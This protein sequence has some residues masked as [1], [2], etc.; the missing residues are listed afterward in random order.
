MIPCATPVGFTTHVIV[1][2]SQLV[3]WTLTKLAGLDSRRSGQSFDPTGAGRSQIRCEAAWLTVI[4]FHRKYLLMHKNI[5]ERQRRLPASAY[6]PVITHTGWS[7]T[8]REAEYSLPE[9]A[10]GKTTFGLWLLLRVRLRTSL[11]RQ[12]RFADIEWWELPCVSIDSHS[13]S[14]DT[15]LSDR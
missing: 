9:F 13:A 4:A 2:P 15:S 3:D 5:C 12:C 14:A 7:N 6:A 10:F 11:R 8:L 1:I